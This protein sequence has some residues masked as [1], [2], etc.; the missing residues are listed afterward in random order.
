MKDILVD[1]ARRATSLKRGGNHQRVPLDDEALMWR[2]SETL[3]QLTEALDGFRT[4]YARQAEVVELKY[5]MDLTEDQIAL[6][7]SVSPVTVRR[8][9]KF[10]RSWLIRRIGDSEIE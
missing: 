2:E 1:R 4:L 8:D 7:L 9:W 6:V 10:A 3:L 5:F